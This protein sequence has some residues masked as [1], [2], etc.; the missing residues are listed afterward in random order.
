MKIID[1]NNMLHREAEIVGWGIHPVRHIFTKYCAPN[2]TTI[3]VWDGPFG[4]FQR[5]KLF[6]PYKQNRRP[7]EESR[8]KFF[9][10][11]KGVLR[12]TPTIQVEC[13]NWEADDVIGTLIEQLHT[14]HKLKVESNDGDYWQHSEKAFLPMISTKWKW[15]SA[16]EC[17][18]YKASVGDTKDG[19]PGITGFGEISFKAMTKETRHRIIECIESKDFQ[20]FETVTYEEWPKRVK[21]TVDLFNELCL[22]YHLNSYWTV[23]EEEI[24]AGTRVGSFN[25]TAAELFMGK[26]LI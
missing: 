2:E 26:F 4:N 7:K 19:I 1:G 10:M 25:L 21:I 3:I 22:Y 6:P 15:M 12:F 24:K 16:K 18:L 17:L 13:P 23:P 8:Y 5:K 11:A 20:R 14:K 9:D